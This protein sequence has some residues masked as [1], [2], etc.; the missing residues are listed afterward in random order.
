[1]ASNSNSKDLIKNIL[2]FGLSNFIPKIMSFLLV[3]VYT[4]YLTTADYGTSDIIMTTVS[5]L[6]PIFTLDINDAVIRFTIENKQDKRAYAIGVRIYILGCVALAVVLGIVAVATE[7]RLT[8]LVLLFV[9]FA[10]SGD[11]Q[12]KV[13]YLR[14]MERVSFLSLCTIVCNFVTLVANVLFIVV[15]RFG[16]YGFISSSIVGYFTVNAIVFVKYHKEHRALFSI[17]FK[18]NLAYT[19]EMLTYSTPL[20]L[21]GIAWWITSSSDRYV[22]SWLIGVSAT[23]I[24]SVASKIPSIL[25]MV[26]S[27]FTPAWNLKVYNIYKNEDGMEYF[28]KIYDLYNFVLVFA[29]SGL[30]FLDKPLAKFM[31]SNEF[32]AAWKYVPV[33][34]ISVVLLSV[35]ACSGV[36]F[37]VYKQSQLSAKGSIINM[38]LN[39]CLNFILVYLIGIQG[40]AI[41]TLCSYAFSWCFNWYH[42]RK[43]CTI[44]VNLKKSVIMY[45][46][47]GVEALIVLHIPQFWLSGIVVLIL[48][49]MNYQQVVSLIR[50]G[51]GYVQEL[52]MKLKSMYER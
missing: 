36:M 23:G 10:V 48:A 1:M 4:A 13:A 40:A 41:A 15:F 20:I 45:I 31:F 43:M 44:P 26:Q 32:Y 14:A 38:C 29:C 9:L 46:L 2:L 3:P 11:Y 25:Q 7:L 19:K 28:G 17:P 8:Y 52:S 33:L 49:A 35:N 51:I 6:L 30:I 16:V 50:S 22:L 18:P 27:V 39:T 24:Y 47:L 5:L 37:G 34:L 42:I 12:L 21:S